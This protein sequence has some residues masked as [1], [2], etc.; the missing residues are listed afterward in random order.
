M[1]GL[2]NVC[3]SAVA[4][5]VLAISGCTPTGDTKDSASDSASCKDGKFSWTVSKDWRLVVLD[6]PVHVTAG[7]LFKAKSIPHEPRTA[8][9]TGASDA[10]SQRAIFKSLSRQLGKEL[11]EPHL[12]TSSEKREMSATFEDEGQAV[13]YRGVKE[14][15]ATYTYA[16]PRTSTKA[17]GTVFTWEVDSSTT[18]LID[19]LVD[20]KENSQSQLARMA[21][22]KRCPAG[23]P[24]RKILSEGN[25]AP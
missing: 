12:S 10:L 24:A 17:S 21:I 6:D 20:P 19:C 5:A 14:V 13:Y 22:S 4:G 8:L 2:R 16:C 15:D 3:L 7:G 11:A 18:G 1:R 23:V 25:T 9:A